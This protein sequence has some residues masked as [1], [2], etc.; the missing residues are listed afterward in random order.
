MKTSPGKYSTTFSYFKKNVSLQHQT[1][2]FPMKKHKLW[3]LILLCLAFSLTA[4]A[5]HFANDFENKY[6]W[7]PPWTNIDII[8]DSISPENQ[9]HCQCD[10][11][12]EYGLGFHYQ[13]P[14]SLY[15]K[16]LQLNFHA[17]YRFP[18]TIGSGEIV[19]T[20]KHE[21]E[22]RFWQNY[23]IASFA[24][25]TAA[26]F[27]VD[28]ELNFPSD[29]LTG[30]LISIFLWNTDKRNIHIDNAT[31]DLTPWQM[32]SFLPE[33]S[34][35]H[36]T[37]TDEDLIIRLPSDNTTPLSYPIGWLNEYILEKD[38]IIEF[39][40][41]K[42]TDGKH[43]LAISDID[44]TT[45]EINDKELIFNTIF[46]KPCRLLRQAIVIPFIDS[47][48]TVYR[49]NMTIDTTL[50]QS[51]YYLDNEGFK[52]GTG[53]R[54]VIA[55]H[56][57]QISSMQLDATNRIAYFNIDY[58]RDHPLIHYPLN[59]SVM[60]QFVD[61]SYRT[62]QAGD[63]W[64]HKLALAFGNDVRD[65]PRIMPIP[66]GYAS[67]IIFTEHAD[68]SDLRTHQ[69][70]YFGN[71]N[72]T[73]AKHATGGFVYYGIPVTKSVFY[74]NPDQ[75][76]NAEASHGTFTGLQA[77]VKTDK[78]FFKFLKQLYGLGYEICLHTPEQYTTT[79]SNLDEALT[80]MERQF[81]SV[82][83]IDHGYNNTSKHNREDMVCDGLDPNSE[84]FAAN[85]WQRHGV[86]YLWNAYYEENRMEQ[87]FFDN[88]IIQPYP[89][90]GDALPN[91]Q[92]T[93]LPNQLSPLNSHLSPLL[94]W[95]TPSTLEATSDSDWDYYYSEERLLKIANNHNVHI[96]HI[97][98]AWTIPHR[99]FWTYDADSTIVALPGMNRALERIAKLRDE[100]KMLPMTVQT[101]L[102]FFSQL[103]NVRYEVIDNHHIKL[104]STDKDIKG[105]TL[106]CTVPIRFNNGQY[107]EFRKE[108]NQ[109][110]VWF[111][112]KANE[113]VTIEIMNN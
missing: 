109:Y 100:R 72:I 29:Y 81:K 97:Y 106:I 3:F 96:T 42:T 88:N 111:N 60:D 41:F 64:N 53:D 4:R 30:N 19:F 101:Y 51:E 63:T 11:T 66:N 10:S 1:D 92:I 5:Q 56:Q 108:G 14:D 73:K 21:E 45:A 37:I 46:N 102:D 31:L 12:M 35:P 57:E 49:K 107:Y 103:K 77:T 99:G 110:Y 68:W 44:A 40:P 15:G 62:I 112:L 26:W 76:T 27:P 91:R 74:N 22:Y 79:P 50:F 33:L 94:T 98:P 78:A 86:Q 58:W 47:T 82:S 6:T 24:N 93:P 95:S 90:Y 105:F 104:T 28:I 16:N 8:N 113:P 65:L 39:H 36:D 75:I 48:L 52:I 83:W 25:D 7:Y 13:I 67:G 2:V 23:L 17:D 70:T 59:D 69:A 18:D 9:Y 80:F 61:I 55:Y 32:P 84:H 85:L 38:T 43:Y 87:W 71:E 20:I 34:I 54:S 89:G